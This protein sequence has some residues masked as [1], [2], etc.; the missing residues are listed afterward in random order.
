M[1]VSFSL[2]SRH[3]HHPRKLE[4]YFARGK[5][6]EFWVK[7]ECITKIVHQK[8]ALAAM[9]HHF[10]SII[11]VWHWGLSHGLKVISSS[12]SSRLP[13]C[14]PWWRVAGSHTWHSKQWINKQKFQLWI[15]IERTS[16]STKG[17]WSTVQRFH[18]SLYRTNL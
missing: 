8:D 11:R 16:V 12:I 5:W 10:M 14:L 18:L 17:P 15:H 1:I 7:L 4:E 9:N 2:L 6:K 3:I 13:H